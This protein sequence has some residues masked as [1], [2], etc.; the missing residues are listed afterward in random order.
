MKEAAAVVLLGMC[1]FATCGTEEMGEMPAAAFLNIYLSNTSPVR[2]A[3][4]R[5]VF[6]SVARLVDESLPTLK[7]G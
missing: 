2:Y 7:G 1:F 6:R 5:F 3:K 4:T